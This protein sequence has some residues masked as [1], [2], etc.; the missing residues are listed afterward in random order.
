MLGIWGEY[1]EI[2]LLVIGVV[3]LLF[4]GLPL[5]LVPMEWARVFRWELP[6]EKNLAIS[7]G[8]SLG[9][10]LSI[11]AIFAIIVARKPAVQPFFFDMMLLTFISMT[12]LHVYG[13]IRRTQPITETVEIGLWVVLGIAGVCFYPV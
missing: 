9:I 13:A 1:N 6:K 12:V 2:F 5:V 4:F 11:I 3:T 8:R 7:F 10:V